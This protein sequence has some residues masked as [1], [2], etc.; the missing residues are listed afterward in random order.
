MLHVDLTWRLEYFFGDRGLDHIT[1]AAIQQGA[2]VTYTCE[3]LVPHTRQARL[4]GLG[5]LTG[6]CSTLCFQSHMT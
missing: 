5:N 2:V 1:R 3:E 4:T 6:A